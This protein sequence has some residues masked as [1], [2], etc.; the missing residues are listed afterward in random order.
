MF[1]F[2]V[3]IPVTELLQWAGMVVVAVTWFLLSGSRGTCAT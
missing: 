3:E 1:P 2:W